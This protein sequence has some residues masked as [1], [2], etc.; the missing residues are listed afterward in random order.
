MMRFVSPLQDDI[1]A[2]S[3]SGN[4]TPIVGEESRY[5]VRLHNNGRNVQNNYLVRLMGQDNTVL[6]S[7]NGPP[8]EGG[9][10]V[11]VIIPWTPAVAGRYSIYGKVEMAG[12][13]SDT[14][15]Q[16]IPVSLIVQPEDTHLVN[17]GT[18]NMF[19]VYPTIFQ[20]NGS[21]YEVL[22]MEDELGFESGTITSLALYNHFADHLVGKLTQIF[23]GSTD[24][25]NL[26]SGYINAS[27]L[28]LVFDGWVDYPAG[29][30]V[31]LINLQSPFLYTGGNLVVMFYRP[32]E[33]NTYSVYNYFKAQILGSNRA[34]FSSIYSVNTDPYDPPSGTLMETVPQTTFFYNSELLQNDL[35]A[36][37]ISGNAAITVGETDNHIIRIRNNGLMDQDNYQVKLMRTGDI[38]IASVAGPPISSMQ[39]LDIVIP[40]TPV[41]TG[42]YLIYGKIE[43]DGDEYPANN[44]TGYLE[45][46]VHPLGPSEVTAEVNDTD[47]AVVIS[48]MPVESAA[49]T[50]RA[51]HEDKAYANKESAVF[52]GYMVYRLQA[53]QEPFEYLWTAVTHKP[54]P[55]LSVAD[56]QWTALPVGDFLWAVKACYSNGSTSIPKFSNTLR[57]STPSGTIGGWVFNIFGE[58]VLGATITNGVMSARPNEFG[59][60]SFLV[61]VGTHTVTVYAPGY[62]TQR[63]EN[64]IVN[65]SQVTEL[66][67]IMEPGIATDDPQNPVPATALNGNYPNPFNPETTISY[68]VKKPGRVKLEVYNIKGQKVC[69]L[70]D[71]EHAA[72]NYKRVFNARD[73]RGRSLSSGVYLIRMSAPGYRKTAKMMLM[74]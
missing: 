57:R 9:A 28:T 64:V 35:G 42:Y 68:S 20:A 72:G 8:V 19:S 3:V 50:R 67:F 14:N 39:T 12:D 17:I 46:I 71:E 61:P 37:A 44:C 29:D 58:P 38:E 33:P 62:V 32:W 5:T 74:Q 1:C 16:T 55:N 23:M 24:R 21:I 48:W 51:R 63:V 25:D 73:N 6:G 27:Q 45:V 56:T 60:F 30:N 65:N 53:D 2:V 4:L 11:D 34:R 31:I 43:Y 69:T 40:F 26:N 52:I 66:L 47:D 70:V 41:E 49:P 59:N 7:A 54:T 10:I 36:M 18:G 15:N 13:E 22:Y